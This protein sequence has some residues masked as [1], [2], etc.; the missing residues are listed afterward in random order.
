MAV[1][2]AITLAVVIVGG[3]AA[4][5]YV[6]GRNTGSAKEKELQSK[7]DSLQS[8]LSSLKTT[9][10]G[11]ATQPSTSGIALNVVRPMQMMLDQEL[12]Y[13][14]LYETQHGQYPESATSDMVKLARASSYD[15]A[16]G[17]P[18]LKC[19]QDSHLLSYTSIVNQ[20]TGKY[21]NFTLYYCYGNQILKK[22]PLDLATP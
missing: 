22:T 21:D 1:I 6:V 12:D 4:A 10:T 19:P 14:T 11:A 13:L 17:G 5:S 8:T 18:V 7:I 15:F 2:F 9:S 20:K 16:S 3:I